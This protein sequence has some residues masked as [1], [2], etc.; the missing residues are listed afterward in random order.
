MSIYQ[1][2]LE[3]YVHISPM[4]ACIQIF[5]MLVQSECGVKNKQRFFEHFLSVIVNVEKYWVCFNPINGRELSVYFCIRIHIANAEVIYLMQCLF[6]GMLF[7]SYQ[8][9]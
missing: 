9:L 6:N 8:Q 3:I 2:N 1:Y 4:W 7:P 5:L